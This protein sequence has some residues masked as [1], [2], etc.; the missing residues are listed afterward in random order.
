MGRRWRF[1]LPRRHGSTWRDSMNKL[2]IGLVVGKNGPKAW[3][4]Q[5]ITLLRDHADIELLGLYTRQPEDREEQSRS[6]GPGTGWSWLDGM[7]TAIAKKLFRMPDAGRPLALDRLDDPPSLQS[8]ADL[9]D[10]T[11]SVHPDLLIQLDRTAPDDKLPSNLP[12]GVWYLTF[13]D[14]DHRPDTIGLASWYRQDHVVEVTLWKAEAGHVAPTV[15]ERSYLGVFKQSWSVNRSRLL[16]KTALIVADN[17]GRLAASPDRF[18]G[19]AAPETLPFSPRAGATLPGSLRLTTR[20]IRGI[21][22]HIWYKLFY[23]EQWQILATNATEDMLTPKAYAQLQPP[24]DRFWA[25]PFAVQRTGKDYIFVEELRFKSGRGEIAVL[26]HQDGK[27]LSAKTIISQPYHMSYPYVFDHEGELYMV[28]E[29]RKNR[30]IEIWKNTS[31]PDGWTRAGELMTDVSAGDTTLFR[32]DGRWWMFTNLSRTS[33]LRSADEL[34]AFYT[35]HPSPLGAT[36]HAHE[37]NPLVR[38]TRCA[39]QGGRVFVDD[40]GRLI[41]CA[42]DTAVRYGYAVLF[43]HV[44]DLT[45]TSFSETLLHKVEPDWRDDVVGH[46][47]FERCGDLCVFDACFVKTRL[48][49]PSRTWLT[50]S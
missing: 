43:F 6:S 11:G 9:A 15:I 27:L 40:E 47:T 13:D 19:A 4:E 29:T 33:K 46:H 22:A 41:R 16:W 31:F 23:V 39:R 18:T 24:R 14:R 32:H 44:R 50:F 34:H 42:Q 25:D 49:S 20:W 10:Q 37:Q 12:H 8:V 1:V 21:V 7:E 30:T 3:H 26:E 45:P 35:D 17:A 36:W 38:D 2:R 5:V 48:P 28:P